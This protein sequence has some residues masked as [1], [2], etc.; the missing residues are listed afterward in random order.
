M[1]H[2]QHLTGLTREQRRDMAHRAAER[3][4][5]VHEA[6]PYPHGTLEHAFFHSDYVDRR[7]ELL[8]PERA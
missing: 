1:H 7:F 2:I 4:D 8:E 6:C 3:G 5:P